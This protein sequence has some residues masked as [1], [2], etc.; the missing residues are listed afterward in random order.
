VGSFGGFG[1]EIV[2]RGW[3]VQW[4]RFWFLGW[5]LGRLGGWGGILGHRTIFLEA[6][7]VWWHRGGPEIAGRLLGV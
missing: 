1:W 6:R 4:S 7:I 2:G 3:G 5:G